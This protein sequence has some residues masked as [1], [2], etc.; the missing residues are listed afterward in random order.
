MSSTIASVPTR[1]CCRHTSSTGLRAIATKGPDHRV[2]LLSCRRAVS[3]H[4]LCPTVTELVHDIETCLRSND[5]KLYHCGFVP[6]SQYAGPMPTRNATGALSISD[7]F[8]L[9]IRTSTAGAGTCLKQRLVP[10]GGKP[11]QCQASSRLLIDMDAQDAQ[12]Y[13]ARVS[14]VM[15]STIASVPTRISQNPLPGYVMDRGYTDF[16]RLYRFT[17]GLAFCIPAGASA[18][19]LFM[20][21]GSRKVDQCPPGYAATTRSDCVDARPLHSGPDSLRRISYYAADIDRRFV[22]LSKQ[23]LAACP[24]YRATLQVPLAGRT[25]LSVDQTI[26]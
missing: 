14:T 7:L 10:R 11:V 8:P 24:D 21:A 20:P 22:F 26:P 25:V 2:G 1:I 3:V 9:L 6:G 13:L 19:L 16:A 23:F 12:D 18:L 15:S 4:G 5:D 17:R